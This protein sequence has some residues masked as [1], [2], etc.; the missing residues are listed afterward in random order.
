M[1][2]TKLASANHPTAFANGQLLESETTNISISHSMLLFYLSLL[3][4]YPHFSVNTEQCILTLFFICMHALHSFFLYFFDYKIL[5]ANPHNMLILLGC[6]EIFFI[7]ASVYTNIYTCTHVLYTYMH[8][9]TSLNK[10]HTIS[11]PF[12]VS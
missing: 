1:G 12:Q 5:Y 3:Y 2:S 7:Y 4:I 6:F 10:C 8:T 9:Y 11:V